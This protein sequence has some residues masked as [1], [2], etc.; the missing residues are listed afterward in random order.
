MQGMTATTTLAMREMT[1]T[2][3]LTISL[4][5]NWSLYLAKHLYTNS[6]Q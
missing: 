5:S 2:T 4:V 1:V 3:T 6:L